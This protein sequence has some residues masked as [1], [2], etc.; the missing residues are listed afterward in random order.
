MLSDVLV[1]RYELMGCK[2][3]SCMIVIKSEENKQIYIWAGRC[4]MCSTV[5][6]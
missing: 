1:V 6:V 4:A 2:R 5:N 3:V